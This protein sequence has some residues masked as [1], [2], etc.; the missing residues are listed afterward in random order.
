MRSSLRNDTIHRTIEHLQ[1][2]KSAPGF[3]G[4]FGDS[5]QFNSLAAATSLHYIPLHF[6]HGIKLD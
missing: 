3:R 4:T 2:G 6:A 1:G 5:Y